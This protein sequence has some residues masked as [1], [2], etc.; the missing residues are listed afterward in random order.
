MRT[1]RP[2]RAVKPRHHISTLELLSAV[3]EF[4]PNWPARFG[5][6]EI[7]DVNE[8]IDRELIAGTLLDAVT[9][10]PYGQRLLHQD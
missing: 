2:S 10:S 1:G 4:G 3:G 5:D 6:H 9:L 8:A 7:A